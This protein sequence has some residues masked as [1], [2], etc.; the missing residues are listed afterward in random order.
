MHTMEMKAVKLYI[1][2]LCV[3]ACKM[4]ASQIKVRV[5]FSPPPQTERGKIIWYYGILIVIS[6]SL[7]K[8]REQSY[9]VV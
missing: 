7:Q 3:G 1:I 4:Y 2:N 5:I 9:K 6:S 8:Q